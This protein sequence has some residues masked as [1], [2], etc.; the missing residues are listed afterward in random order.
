MHSHKALRLWVWRALQLRLRFRRCRV[1][2][3]L[4]IFFCILL[5]LATILR[6]LSTKVD[7]IMEG[8]FRFFV[9]FEELC[10]EMQ[11]LSSVAIEKRRFYNKKV[12][13][14]MDRFKAIP[15]DGGEAARRWSSATG[16]PIASHRSG[17]VQAHF[18]TVTS[19]YSPFLHALSVSAIA[20]GIPLNVLGMG[21][22]NFGFPTRMHLV[23]SYI[24][25][26]NLSD[27]DVI[28]MLDT[29]ALFSGEGIEQ[30][31]E[32][33]I[34]STAATEEEHL[35][36]DIN[37]IRS[38]KRWSPVTF[39]GETECY[40]ISIV[41][42]SACHID[43]DIVET[44]VDTWARATNRNIPSNVGG[45]INSRRFMN[46]GVLLGRVWAVRRLLRA[47]MDFMAAHSPLDRGDKWICDQ[48]IFAMLHL[49]L[50]WWEVKSGAMDGLP[51]D[52]P[53]DVIKASFFSILPVIPIS[54]RGPHGLPAG[55][56]GIDEDTRLAVLLSSEVVFES[57]VTLGGEAVSL[58]TIPERAV[59]K[60]I[61]GNNSTVETVSGVRR[62]TMQLAVSPRAGVDC[63]MGRTLS[64]CAYR[65]SVL[66]MPK[67][68]VSP[69][70][71][72]WH[73]SGL[74]KKKIFPRFRTAFPWYVPTIHDPKA[75]RQLIE[76]L[77]SAPAMPI[78]RIDPATDY[79]DG[80]PRLLRPREDT[81]ADFLQMCQ[82][83]AMI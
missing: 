12:R 46:A 47:S 24:G 50:R 51:H 79:P 22:K 32:A 26:E 44:A 23:D 74:M 18:V 13:S 29:D 1:G 38:H 64:H 31:L 81:N 62:S 33:F 16:L 59:E 49:Q 63:F 9:P 20:T 77:Q 54:G 7:L 45:A 61:R 78:W 34:A 70:P 69:T 11:Q 39:P 6:M 56:I 17:T 30:L 36:Y 75:A 25:L 42:H 65:N 55:M 14:A 21:W 10:Q 68:Q 60:Y 41:S 53:Q 28:V 15:A 58:N 66:G 72:I 80:I 76:I 73:F 67:G 2:W 40:R 37:D 48:S 52:V 4:V 82:K 35:T 71:A 27:A 8:P 5:S 83:C 57:T 43:Y 3:L 19:N